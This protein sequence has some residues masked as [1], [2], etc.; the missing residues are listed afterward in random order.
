MFSHPGRFTR[1]GAT[2]PTVTRLLQGRHSVHQLDGTAHHQRKALYMQLLDVGAT[3]RL[4]ELFSQQW[5]A[6]TAAWPRRPEVDG[7][8]APGQAR[9]RCRRRDRLSSTCSAVFR[10]RYT[11]RRE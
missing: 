3:A 9:P 1:R 5:R 10:A 8:R 2:P 4:V 6:R 11:T 7:P